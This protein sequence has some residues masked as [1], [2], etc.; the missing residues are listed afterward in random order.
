[1]ANEDQEWRQCLLQRLRE[2]NRRD[3]VPFKEIIQQSKKPKIIVYFYFVIV[4]FV[5]IVYLVTI[6]NLANRC[7][8]VKFYV[9]GIAISLITLVGI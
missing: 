9:I 3:V 2:R 6:N 4:C 1:M 8:I 7:L 5:V